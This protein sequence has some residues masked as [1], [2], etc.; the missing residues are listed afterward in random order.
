MTFHPSVLEAIGNT[1]LIKLKG[2]SEATGCTILGKAEFLNPG[3]SVKDR[4][5]LYIIRDA[6][7]KGLLR[8]GGVI[9]EGTAGNTGIGLTLVA[10]ALGYRTVIV[11]PET[12]SQEKKDALKL[13][14]AELVEVP[15]VAYK[16][17][18][19]YV[20]VS[21]RLAEQLAKT[22]PNGAI[23]ANQFDNVANRQAHIET[24]AK[25]I[26]KD[27]D[28]KVD[29]FICSVG[30]GGTLAGVAAGLKA[31]KSDVKIGI[32]DPDGAALYEFYQNGALKSEGSSITEGIGQGRITAN[33][34][35]FTPDYA[36]RIPDAEALP[37]L[38]DLVENEGLC[39]GGSTAINI[40][41]AVN[42]ARDL[43]P[44]HTVVTILCDYGNR[45]QSK[46]FN[47]D[48]LTSKG[49]PVPGWMAKSPYIRVPYE[50][51]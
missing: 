19:N 21:G 4:A 44:G 5:A 22:E 14:G 24:T 33:L 34:E 38:F 26:W 15:A 32:A 17:P 30:S 13:L 47:P 42:L 49:L 27:T 37:Y 40:A 7:R 23:W 11:I 36:Y 25:E 48:F 35:G 46:L 6:E 28:G 50:P 20:K 29:G 16:N 39:L 10:K 3:Q 18:N 8:P 9:V 45:Y 1:P 41:G 43:G 12:Q 51:V 31:F 2:A